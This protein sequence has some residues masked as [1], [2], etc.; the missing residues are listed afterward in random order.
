LTKNPL[1]LVF[2]ISIWWGVELGLGA[3]STEVP[4]GDETGYQQTS[5]AK[6]VLPNHARWDIG[7]STAQ[8]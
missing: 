1:I 3:K 7:L 5:I 8:Q 2:H 6:T 4:R